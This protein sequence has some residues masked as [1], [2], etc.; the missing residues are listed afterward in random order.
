MHRKVPG[1]PSSPPPPSYSHSNINREPVRHSQQRHRPLF[2]PA[3]ARKGGL[4]FCH[5]APEY[6]KRAYILSG[7]RP[8]C[9]DPNILASIFNSLSYF[10]NESGNIYTHLISLIAFVGIA[11]N[12]FFFAN[13]ELTFFDKLTSLLYFA[14][15]IFCFLASFIYHALSHKPHRV[16]QKALSCDLIGIVMCILGSYYIGLWIGFRCHLKYAFMYMAAITLM[17]LPL[18]G[19]IG[20]QKLRQNHMVV[21][22]AFSVVVAAGIIPTYHF[23]S[24]VDYSISSSLTIVISL[25]IMFS[26]YGTGLVLYAF[27]IPER[28]WPGYFD[29]V[30]ASHQWWHLCVT[31][32]VFSQYIGVF[33]TFKRIS[34]GLDACKNH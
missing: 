14:S 15:V 19:V 24:I 10:H 1:P 21:A 17:V 20:V 26:F 25:L 27:Q 13:L 7:Y 28:R 12:H 2:E 29:Y 16:Y 23:G 8:L 33:Y 32:A 18:F 4:C 30:F 5:A 11:V 34:Q 31:L 9:E 3:F 22:P 6:S